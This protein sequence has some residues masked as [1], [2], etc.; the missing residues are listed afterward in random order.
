MKIKHNPVFNTEEV[1]KHYTEKDG[2]DVTYVCTTDLHMS[3][4]P[5]DIFYRETPHPEFGNK[6]F[7][8]TYMKDRGVVITNGDMVEGF[9]IPMI[10]DDDGMYT[11]SRSHHDFI[12]CKNGNMIDGGRNYVRSRGVIKIMRVRDGLFEEVV[13]K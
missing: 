11:Y 5:C 10:E 2:V 12:Q 13:K 7:G 1:C 9:E 6:Y 4:V 3:D 8:L